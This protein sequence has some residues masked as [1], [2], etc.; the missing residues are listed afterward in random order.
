MYLE[1]LRF[2]Y[3]YCAIMMNEFNIGN[4]I[5]RLAKTTIRAKVRNGYTLKLKQTKMY[6]DKTYHICLCTNC[7]RF[8]QDLNIHVIKFFM[9]R[10]FV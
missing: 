2:F 10:F 1:K 7:F 4:I 6:K 3:D 5:D 9:R 8:L